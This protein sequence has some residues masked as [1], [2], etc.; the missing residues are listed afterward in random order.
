MASNQASFL[1]ALHSSTKT[2]GVATLNLYKEQNHIQNGNFNLGK[3]L[4]KKLFSCV[5]AILPAHEWSNIDRIAVATGPGGFTGTRI[6]IGMAR[7][8]SQQRQCH[9]D[10]ISSF[11]LMAWRIKEEINTEYGDTFWIKKNLPR[12][13]VVGGK[14]LL[15]QGKTNTSEIIEIES[16]HLLKNSSDTDQVYEFTESIAED[17][18]ILLQLCFKRYQKKQ[19]SNWKDVLPIYP[20]APV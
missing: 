9:L 16:P 19:P 2:F 1:L 4:S 15:K 20:I 5:D 6:T 3:E 8:L 17:T 18:N 12:R 7:I 14:Y 13:G 11:E 10:G